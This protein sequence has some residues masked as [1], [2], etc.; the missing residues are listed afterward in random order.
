MSDRV[1]NACRK[2]INGHG[3]PPIEFLDTLI[4]TINSLP[5]EVFE[6]NN[7]YD[8]YSV[9]NGVLGPYND[10]KHRRAVMCE[11]LRVVA[12]FE[13]D[14]DWNEGE[15]K[16]KP[17]EKKTKEA[18]ETGAF[19]VSWDSMST[20]N[21]LKTC[22]EKL[23]GSLAVDTFIA[24]MK[25]NHQLSIE[26][27]A[28]L[29]RF[30]TT[31]CYTINTKSMVISNV[32]KSAV[33]EFENFLTTDTVSAK[34]SKSSNNDG[35]C[36]QKLLNIA[37]DNAKLKDVQARAAHKLFVYDGEKYPAN[38]CAITLSILLQDAGIA[39]KDI[40]R[41]IDL[42]NILRDNRGWKLIKVGDQQ[43]G[44]IG[45]TCGTKPNHG[46]DHIYLVVKRVDADKMIIAD[47][48]DTVVHERYASG[49]QKKT[50]TKYF[51]RA[52]Q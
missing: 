17:V 28:R 27:C 42:T 40:Y 8:I 30:D 18:E 12:A 41:A 22:V 50:P 47:N 14:W 51:L 7:K 6:R 45:T 26:Y 39:V 1:Y 44:D 34:L 35:P 49:N 5:D 52:A 11:V 33:A 19:Q 25:S 10:L 16:N 3:K 9:M 13:S 31:W 46:Y 4:D 43:P 15:D 24:S 48:Q 36:I 20:D 21:S 2:E 32:R 38:G 29:L 23:A 37:I